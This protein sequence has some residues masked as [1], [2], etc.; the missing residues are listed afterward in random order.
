MVSPG[1]SVS[2]VLAWLEDA[3]GIPLSCDVRLYKYTCST[4]CS[5]LLPSLSASPMVGKSTPHEI[6]RSTHPFSNLLTSSL[7]ACTSFQQS[8]GRL[9]FSSRHRTTSLLATSTLSGTSFTSFRV[10][11]FLSSSA[12]SLAALCR[13]VGV[14]SGAVSSA[15]L[16]RSEASRRDSSSWSLR[17]SLLTRV[18]ICD[19][20]SCARD[21]SV[22]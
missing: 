18:W 21:A 22:W 19:S 6:T 12:I 1:T 16:A 3:F 9:S 7:N 14:L 11:S 20:M 2:S 10:C 4:S 17:S 5:R 15:T 13:L 8:S